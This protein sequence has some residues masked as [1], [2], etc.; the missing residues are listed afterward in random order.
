MYIATYGE[1][2]T[3]WKVQKV[4]EKYGIYYRPASCLHG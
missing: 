1:P 4:I 2:M 3:A